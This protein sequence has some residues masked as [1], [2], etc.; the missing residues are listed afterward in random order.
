MIQIFAQ[1]DGQ[2]QSKQ[3]GIITIK[4][5][6]FIEKKIVFLMLIFY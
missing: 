3:C 6:N 4:M 5:Y 1:E 2:A